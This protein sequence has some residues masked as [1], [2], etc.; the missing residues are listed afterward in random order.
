MRM[1]RFGFG[2]QDAFSP[3]DERLENVTIS[4][5]TATG[6]AQ[7]AVFRLGPGG[8]IARH[9]AAV[10]Q[11]LAVLDGAGLVSGGDGEFHPIEA[12]EAVFWA[13]GEEHETV[14]DH[15]LTALIVEASD[16]RPLG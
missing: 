9:P 16:L 13:A 15:G 1:E 14:S 8:R 11:V 12:G 10:P 7:A 4:P 6:S 2:P 5:L 3:H